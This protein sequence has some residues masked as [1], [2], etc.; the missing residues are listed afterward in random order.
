[1]AND[2]GGSQ[3]VPRP[4]SESVAKV[5]RSHV[6]DSRIARQFDSQQPERSMHRA[7]VAEIVSAPPARA[8]RWS[9]GGLGW[10]KT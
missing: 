3:N 10:A 4:R 9:K 6:A 2:Y 7:P 8:F 1:M 5:D